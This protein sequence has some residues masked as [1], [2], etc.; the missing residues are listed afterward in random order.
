MINLRAAE[1]WNSCLDASDK[2]LILGGSGWFG[3]TAHL[4]TDLP[5]ERVLSIASRERN[6][7][8]KDISYSVVPYDFAAIEAFAPTVV[9]DFWFLTREKIDTHGEAEYFENV[10]SMI[11]RTRKVVALPSVSRVV[12]V[13]SGAAVSADKN[14]ESGGRFVAYGALKRRSEEVLAQAAV[15]QGFR[16]A[17]ARVYSVSG[18]LV[19]RPKSYAFSNLALQALSGKIRI[20]A[21]TPVRRKFVAVEDVLAVAL[22]NLANGS[23]SFSSGGEEIEIGDLA[24]L[25]SEVLSREIPIE[26]ERYPAEGHHDNYYSEDKTWESSVKAANFAPLNLREQAINVLDFFSARGTSSL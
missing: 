14:E 5:R 8:I 15:E 18:A 21:R 1:L 26:R 11:D 9:L 25:F 19:T 4:M 22:S 3:R 13:S 20:E 16:L 23:N 7:N 2:V 6:V 17:V 10:H 24:G 12:S